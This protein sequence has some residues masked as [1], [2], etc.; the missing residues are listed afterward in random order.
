MALPGGRWRIGGSATV[1]DT[2]EVPTPPAATRLL[3]A[4]TGT[5]PI[6]RTRQVSGVSAVGSRTRAV[7][8]PT[9]V[10]GASRI[11]LVKQ[12]ASYETYFCG[13]FSKA[14]LQPGEQK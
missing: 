8:S 7:K 11:A 9:G 13:S 1:S 2:I 6:T 14:A 3:L 4:T 5:G 12:E 10:A